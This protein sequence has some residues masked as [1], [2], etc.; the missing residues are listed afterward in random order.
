MIFEIPDVDFD[1]ISLEELKEH[2]EICARVENSLRSYT[3]NK[4][5]GEIIRR[6]NASHPVTRTSKA[7]V[8]LK[9]YT[10]DQILR[11]ED[12]DFDFSMDDFR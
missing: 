5:Q 1:S 3:I 2:S 8:P 6:V 9:R 12:D 4:V 7:P 10:R 11:G